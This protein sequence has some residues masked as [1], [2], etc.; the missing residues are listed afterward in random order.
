M[1]RLPVYPRGHRS[2]TSETR[3]TKRVPPQDVLLIMLTGQK[4]FRVA[5]RTLGSA[6]QID[7][8]MCPGDAIYIPALTFHSG[9]ARAEAI[10][11]TMLSIALEWEKPADRLTA[12][13]AVEDWRTTRQALLE[14][15]PTG[16]EHSGHTWAWASSNSGTATLRNVFPQGSARATLLERFL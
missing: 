2:H 1:I 10:D 9:G 11:S 16:P 4:R 7:H 13:E 15:L 6:V 14:R 12:T 8:L 5:G 3:A